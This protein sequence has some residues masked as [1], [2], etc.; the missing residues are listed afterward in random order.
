MSIVSRHIVRDVY[1]QNYRQAIPRHFHRVHSCRGRG[2]V[3]IVPDVRISA[4][5]WV[6][7]DFRLGR[8]R[9]GSHKD[10]W[11]IERAMVRAREGL[12]DLPLASM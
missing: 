2:Q 3:H 11:L 10:C 4:L 5:R 8:V 6:A 1:R 7:V 9:D 12:P